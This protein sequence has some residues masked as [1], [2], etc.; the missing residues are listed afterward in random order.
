MEPSQMAWNG[1]NPGASLKGW[2]EKAG[3]L[4]ASLGK[5]KNMGAIQGNHGHGEGSGTSFGREI[6]RL[7]LA[8]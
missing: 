3:N 5:E 7:I 8:K 1:R 6:P 2:P 4:G